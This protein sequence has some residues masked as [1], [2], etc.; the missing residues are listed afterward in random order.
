MERKQSFGG[1][2]KEIRLSSTPK[3][4]LNNLSA[5]MG[6]QLSYLSDVENGRK[7]PF[8]GDK[9]EQFASIMNISEEEKS[10]LYDLAAR[11]SDS[12]PED[13]VETI[14]YT[15]QGDQ[16]RIAL[17]LVKE[18]KGDVEMWKKLIREME[19]K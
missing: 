8:S 14:M 16:A 11:D 18:G 6:M 12:V 1:R 13:I 2:I 5:E 17:R 7:K 19:K 9:I 10:E 15:E 3:K 4:T